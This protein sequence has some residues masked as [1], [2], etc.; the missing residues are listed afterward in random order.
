MTEE[1]GGAELGDA[2]LAQRL[3]AC[4]GV[5]A[6]LPSRS[7]FMAAAG[8]SRMVKGHYR[9]IDH[10]DRDAVTPAGIMA[11]HRRRT[12]RRM[13]EQ[14]TALLIQDGTD[15]N[16]ATHHGCEGLG[17]IGRNG[18]GRSGTLG[19]HMHSTLAVNGDG[20]PLGV[21]RIEFDAPDGAAEKGRPLMERKTGR[22][23]RGLEDSVALASRLHGVRAVAVM[24]RE[25]DAFEILAAPRKGVALLVRARHDRSLG[26]GRGKLFAHLAA[27][28][29][30]GRMSVTVERQSARNS[31]RTQKARPARAGRRAPGGSRAPLGQRVAAR[32][33]RV[34]IRR[35]A[36]PDHRGR[37]AGDEASLRRQP[38]DP[39][40][41]ADHA[42]GQDVRR[43]GEGR[44]PVSPEVAHRGLAQGPEVRLQD[45]GDRPPQTRA[46]R[47]GPGDQ[48]RHRLRITALTELGRANPGLPAGKAF[49]DVELAMLADF[50]RERGRP[51]PD[52]LGSAFGL[53]AMMGGYL[54]RGSEAPP[55]NE[56]LWNGHSAL[57]FSAWIVG[58]SRGLGNQ[59]RL[60]KM[61]KLEDTCG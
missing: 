54:N 60:G 43:R 49:S 52:S 31:T 10:P 13:S 44:R 25:G 20:V 57:S 9:L 50:A 5:Q 58:L 48:R 23:L 61:F 56:I 51:P 24:D 21:V 36:R 11:G 3:V 22:W 42:S 4:A 33:Q 28:R 59:S 35:A 32:A 26:R 17:V 16:L 41:A 14:E 53:V 12:L 29:P 39:V 18:K 19:L 37:G 2:R 15:V 27:L 38:A 40:A 45:R 47:A 8:D 7:F 1:F 34:G 55:G 46:R 6:R 30:G